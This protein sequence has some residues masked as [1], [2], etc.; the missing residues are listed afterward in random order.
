MSISRRQVLLF[1][2]TICGLGG[3]VYFHQNLTQKDKKVSN[4]FESQPPPEP[5]SSPTPIAVAPTGFFAPVKGDVRLLVISDLNNRY[6][7]TDYE[8]QVT[9]SIPLIPQ[10]E[11]DL[12]LCAGDMVAGQKRSLSEANIKAM[13]AGFERDIASPLRQENL[14]F[15]MTMGNHDAS[16]YRNKSGTYVFAKERRLAEEYWSQHQSNLNLDF[17]DDSGFPYYYSFVQNDI[18]YLIW[19][20]SSFIIPSQQL[21]W[22][23]ESLA[24]PSAQTAKLRIVMGHLPLY[25]VAV[26]RN[27]EGAVLSNVRELQT[28]LEE[29]NVHLY[30]SGHHHAYFPARKN[31]LKLLHTGALGSGPRVLLNSD[32]SPRNTLTVID[33]NLDSKTSRYTTY[34]MKTQEV[35]QL[36]ELPERIESL[37]RWVV[38]EDVSLEASNL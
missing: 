16:S 2:S 10:W 8:S 38:R 22:V 15:A 36:Q 19:D 4:K 3:A 17:V 5:L 23:K 20:A 30:I 35:I 14:P 27:K 12:V 11:P 9:A 26:G 33:I 31:Q 28:L 21:E 7:S 32:L 34:N 25:A 18:F 1:L 37:N 24:S 29:N 6:G 13:W